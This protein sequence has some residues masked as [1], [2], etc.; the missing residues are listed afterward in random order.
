MYKLRLIKVKYKYIFI[1]KMI[2]F[3]TTYILKNKVKL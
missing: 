3:L 1:K 2:V